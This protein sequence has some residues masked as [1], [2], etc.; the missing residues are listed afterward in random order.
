MRVLVV[1]DDET[2]CEKL[3]HQLTETGFTV[4]VARDGAEGL[5]A[6]LNYSLDAAIVDIGLPVRSGF[7]VIRTWRARELRFP[8]L[9]LTARSAWQDKVD[10]LNAGA[11]DYVGKPVQFEEVN[12]RLRALARRSKGWASALVICGPFVLDMH[13]RTLRV[14][15]EAV[16]LTTFEYRLLEQLMLNAGQTLS[17]TDLAEHLYNEEMERESNIITQ[18]VSRLRRKLDPQDRL[19]PIE[20]VH[21]DGYRFAVER[22][23]AAEPAITRRRG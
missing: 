22:G 17:R 2:L 18:L 10:G 14:A 19:N 3:R 7:D 23:I 16:D 6:G 12:A 15:G 9:V 20:T 5:H 21:R 11:D 1:E 4:D 8:I 13:L